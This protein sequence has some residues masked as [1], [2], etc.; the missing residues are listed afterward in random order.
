[1]PRSAAG[2]K[3]GANP[4][5]QYR[6]DDKEC[7]ARHES[8]VRGDAAFDEFAGEQA[9]EQRVRRQHK[10]DGEQVTADNNAYRFEHWLDLHV[11]YQS[12]LDLPARHYRSEPVWMKM[13]ILR[14]HLS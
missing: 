5:A 3:A 13:A 11:N 10:N 8:G 6:D 7:C 14:R 1:M 4:C 12:R 9:R 2:S